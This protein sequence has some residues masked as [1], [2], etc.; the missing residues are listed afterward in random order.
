MRGSFRDCSC[1]VGTLPVSTYTVLSLRH[2]V[3]VV[4]VSYTMSVTP[5]S[6][7][8]LPL[9]SLHFRYPLL[10]SLIFRCALLYHPDTIPYQP[11]PWPSYPSST[12]PYHPLAILYNPSCSH[13]P[14]PIAS[15]SR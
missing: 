14:P 1:V 4:T 9:Y 13:T 12:F 2:G 15:T 10:Y 5:H 11:T 7:I 6:I 3:A 8:P